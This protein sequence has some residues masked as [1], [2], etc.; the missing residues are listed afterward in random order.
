MFLEKKI[1]ELNQALAH[2]S[3]QNSFTPKLIFVVF[4]EKPV[5]LP[6]EA[7]ATAHLPITM[8]F[9]HGDSSH[10]PTR[11]NWENLKPRELGR[12]YLQQIVL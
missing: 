8:M 9:K 1:R 10:C 7:S 3:Q 2:L 5:A 12:R 4:A 6:H 11:F